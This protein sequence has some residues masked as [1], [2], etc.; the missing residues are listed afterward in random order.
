MTAV[1]AAPTNDINDILEM[2]LG[3]KDYKNEKQGEPPMRPYWPDDAA[4]PGPVKQQEKGEEVDK[5]KE[6][7]M[8]SNDVSV[9]HLLE[10]IKRKW[11]LELLRHKIEQ[12]CKS[13]LGNSGFCAQRL[14]NLGR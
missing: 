13:T 5:F 12:F 2:I 10:S 7:G 4:L 14:N 1:H 11:Q 6:V 8:E 9:E 3:E